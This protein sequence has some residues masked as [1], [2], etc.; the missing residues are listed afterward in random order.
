MNT[1]ERRLRIVVLDSGINADHPHL[2]PAHSI[3]FGSRLR[4]VTLEADSEHR[5]ALGHGTAVA[6]AIVD[7][8][9]GVDLVSIRLFDQAPTCGVAGLVVALE[10][11][12]TFDP[13]FVN[14]SLGTTDPESIAAFT[15]VVCE[16]QSHGVEVVAP[17]DFHGLASYP[18][19]L[20]GVHGV[21]VDPNRPRE[22]PERRAVGDRYRWY[23]SPYPRDLPGVPR[24]AN[25][26]GVSM[27]VANVTGFLAAHAGSTIVVATVQLFFL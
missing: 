2:A 27:A 7:L 11:A 21:V 6:A 3:T 19:G 15:D 22:L 4:G 12:L 20:D 26:S 13:D 8:A 25:L 5:D 23:A 9:P 17:A 1:G 16:A 18:G 24:A 14:L 10:H